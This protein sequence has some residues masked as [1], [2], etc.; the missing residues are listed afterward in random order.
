MSNNLRSRMGHIVAAFTLLAAGALASTPA[1]ASSACPNEQVRQ[2]SNTNPATGQPYSLGLPECRAYEMV[3][4]LEKQQHDAIQMNVA[5]APVV[6]PGGESIGWQSQGDFLNPE[7]YQVQGFSP[8][9]PYLSARGEAGWLTRSGFPPASL[10]EDPTRPNSYLL[11]EDEILSANLEN[12]AGCGLGTLRSAYGSDILCASREPDGAWAA[13]PD[14]RSL[15]GELT[16][17]PFLDGASADLNTAIVQTNEPGAHFLPGDDTGKNCPGLEGETD[18]HA[19]YEVGGIGTP[20]PRLR[21]VDVDNNGNLIG[22]E[23]AVHVG[24]IT[25]STY[26]AVSQDGQTIFF[27]ATPAGGVP[28]VYARIGGKETVPVSEPSSSQCTEVCAEAARQGAIYDGATQDGSK[29]FF[30]TAEPLVNADTDETPDLYEYDFARP[31][32]ERLALVSAGGQGDLSHGAGAEVGGVVGLSEDGSHVYFTA[33]G[34]LTSLPNAFGQSAIAGEK[35]LYGYA[36]TGETKF[37]A[38][39]TSHDSAELGLRGQAAQVT[40]NGQYLVFDTYAHLDTHDFNSGQAVYRYDFDTGQLTWV[41]HDMA[42]MTAPDEGL[43]AIVAF[44]PLTAGGGALPTVNDANRAISEDGSYIVFSSSEKLQ[45]GA[46]NSAPNVYIWHNGAVSMVSDGHDP[47][48]ATFPVISATG[49]D[50]FFETRERLVAQDT[51][52]LGDIYDARIDGGFPEPAKEAICSGE[53]CQ[54]SPPA[55][56]GLPDNGTSTFTAGG[57]LIPVSTAFPAPTTAKPKPLTKAQELAKALTQCHKD[58]GKKKRASCEKAARK[59]YSPPKAK[60]KKKG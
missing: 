39:L 47:A 16:N 21:L 7:N 32:S 41:S 4:P 53:S 17:R 37:I 57:N 40:P 48:G 50:V 38:T 13:T 43:N 26:Q 8:S 49:A 5:Y 20:S 45:T 19:L 23:N 52:T 18:C 2:E 59:K 33:R 11:P 60:G 27:T 28:T 25:G 3:S 1:L 34:V 14:Y 24:S 42:G 56:P 44:K 22:P 29:V 10:I 46:T 15:G 54:G 58:K 55:A 35:N 9:N 31:P 36:D 6:S 30:T 51:D 12:E